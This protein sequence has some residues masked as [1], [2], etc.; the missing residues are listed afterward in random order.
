MGKRLHVVKRQ[1]EYGCTEAFNWCFDKF[2]KLLDV[3]GCNVCADDESSDFWE[4]TKDEYKRAITI[5]KMMKDVPMEGDYKEQKEKIDQIYN[6]EKYQE[7]FSNDECILSIT[8]DDIELHDVIDSVKNIDID[9]DEL[10][11]IMESFLNEADKKSNWIQF[12][13]W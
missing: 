8:T 2:R 13:A 11:S 12:E 5:L 6:S 9:L 7:L 3:L 10:I 1:R 4:M